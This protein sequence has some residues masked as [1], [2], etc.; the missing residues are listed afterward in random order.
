MK[1]KNNA[2]FD[3]IAFGTHNQKGYENDVR[4]PAG[5]TAEVNGP[6]LGE[7]GSGSCH[8][9]LIGEITCQETPDD[10]NG[11][12]VTRGQP[13]CLGDGER[14]ITIR[15]YADMPEEHVAEWRRNNHSEPPLKSGR[16]NAHDAGGL[17]SN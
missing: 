9:A 11:L 10:K 14:G 7:M 4:I 3:V 17:I 16:R 5:Q 13:L 1:V 12:Q 15:H 2:P 8:V 6:Y